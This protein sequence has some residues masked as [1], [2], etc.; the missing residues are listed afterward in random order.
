M[1]T[2]K[3][4]NGV[5]IPKLGF[6]TWQ[7]E[8]GEMAYNSV[9]KALE[10]GYNHIDTAQA[11]GNEKSVG[12]A[13]IDSGVNRED[14][15]LT[16]KVW[17]TRGTYEE[18]YSSIQRS[19]AKLQVDY[20]DLLLIH[21]PNPKAFR[22]DD[23]WKERNK[24]V[25]RAMEDFYKEGKIKAVGI[26]N[27]Q[28]HHIEEL[29]KTA[30]VVPHV[31]QIS[32]SPGLTQ[33]ELVKYCQDKEIQIEAYSPLGKGGAFSNETL[34]EMAAK[35]DRTVAQIC[36]RWSLHHGFLPLPR[37]KTPANI[38]SNL[39]IFDFDLSPEDIERLNHLEGIVEMTDPDKGDF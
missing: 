10:Y 22:E 16:T 12:Q 23:A 32:L 11:Y 35:Y 38:K 8:E 6:G 30:E 2:Y 37:S 14:I 20:L 39:N 34:K 19:M 15:F 4:S 17:N 28:I 31:N 13:I 1:E 3:L 9:S 7:L 26:S 29:L 33:D 18:A 27:F 24:E 36:L 21:W 25:W 5:E